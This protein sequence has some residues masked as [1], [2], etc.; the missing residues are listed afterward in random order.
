M[1]EPTFRIQMAA[2]MSG[3]KEGLIRAWERRY[4]VLK[5]AR[6]PSGYRTFTRGDIEV[7]KKQGWV[8]KQAGGNAVRGG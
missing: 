8:V 7:L 5:P 1:S 3:V 2:E 4:G 6:S